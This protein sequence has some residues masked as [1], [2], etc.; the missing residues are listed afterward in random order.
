MSKKVKEHFF[1]FVYIVE[2]RGKASTLN[3]SGHNSQKQEA[4]HTCLE[5]ETPRRK[6]WKMRRDLGWVNEG[7]KD[8]GLG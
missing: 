7:T 3:G 6:N 2:A 1:F 4:K 5:K 8:H